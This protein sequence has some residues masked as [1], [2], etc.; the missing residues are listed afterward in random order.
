MLEIFESNQK[1]KLESKLCMHHREILHIEAHV[2]RTSRTCRQKWR[3]LRCEIQNF[4]SEIFC[5]VSHVD[6]IGKYATVAFVFRKAPLAASTERA[7]LFSILGFGNLM[8][9][10]VPRK[11][12]KAMGA[13]TNREIN[14]GLFL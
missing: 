13:T 12:D 10:N 5:L 1:R 3:T 11:Y 6:W 7:N 4:R 14:S 8:V 2:A 9:R